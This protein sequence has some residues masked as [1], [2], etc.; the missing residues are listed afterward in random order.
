M[1]MERLPL[2]VECQ[3]LT[4]KGCAQIIG[5]S[6]LTSVATSPPSTVPAGVTPPPS[7]WSYFF[8]ADAFAQAVGTMQPPVTA[9]PTVWPD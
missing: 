1:Q 2:S 3:M 9:D 4:H 6:V 7:F 8:S 5:G